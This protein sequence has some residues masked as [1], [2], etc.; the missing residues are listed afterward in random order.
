M[1]FSTPR[2]TG[3]VP[4]IKQQQQQQQQPGTERMRSLAHGYLG[5]LMQLSPFPGSPIWRSC[6][7]M[8]NRNEPEN[9]LTLGQREKPPRLVIVHRKCSE[10]TSGQKMSPRQPT[11]GVN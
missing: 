4:W 3:R 11:G 9:F 2:G 7:D 1:I 8:S 10:I 6:G 5:M